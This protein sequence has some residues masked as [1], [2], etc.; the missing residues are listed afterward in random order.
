MWYFWPP[1]IVFGEDALDYLKEL[2]GHKAIIVTDPG[3][4]KLGFIDIVSK[5]LESIGMKTSIFSDVKPD[6]SDQEIIRCSKQMQ[7]FQPD[8]IVAVGGGSSIDTAKGAWV[9]YE[10]PDLKLTDVSQPSK[11]AAVVVTNSSRVTCRVPRGC[12]ILTGN[13]Y[14][15]QVEI[16]PA[17]AAIPSHK[18]LVISAII[19]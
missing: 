15:I 18:Y 8:L 4:M 6:P 14:S 16:R 13:L 7:T 5:K 2:K 3:I 11:A 10:R 1:K 17:I 12:I 19:R 9:L